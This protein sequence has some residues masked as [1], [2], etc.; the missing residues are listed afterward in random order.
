MSTTSTGPLGLPIT[1]GDA[2]D[3]YTK[4]LD[5][6]RNQTQGDFQFQSDAIQQATQQEVAGDQK[7][8][9]SYTNQEPLVRA[10]YANLAKEFQDS[11]A[12]ETNTATTIGNENIGKAEAFNADTGIER[13]EGAVAANVGQA[14]NALSANVAQIANKYDIQQTTLV[15]QMNQQIGNLQT[16]AAK[17]E[18]AG[19]TALAN[20]LRQQ[21]QLKST[22]DAQITAIASAIQQ[23][24]DSNTKNALQQIMDAAT[25]QHN[26][27]M[28]QIAAFNAKETARHN[29]VSESIAASNAAT[30]AAN[31]NTSA[32]RLAMD[33]S[34][35]Y[36]PSWG[37]QTAAQ[38]GG[39]MFKDFKGNPISAGAYVTINNNG[40]FDPLKV[41]SFL[42]QNGK[43]ND[44]QAAHTIQNTIQASLG[45]QDLAHG[46]AAD[47]LKLIQD[48]VNSATPQQKQKLLSDLQNTSGIG[49]IF[50]GLNF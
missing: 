29:G 48:R 41:A 5:V 17:Y 18:A 46:T 11:Q 35:K 3:Q 25:I 36:M 4:Y 9:D 42:Q 47:Q 14:Q 44:V 26:Q 6:A 10:T 13:G 7:T 21:A 1:T 37:F 2:S 19:N 34:T 32:Q 43:A 28:A 27:D 15:S 22:Q 31:A 8:A 40:N 12:I 16:E 24:Q 50:N 39:L 45:I 49:H 20:G 33:A 38:G 30:S 23:T